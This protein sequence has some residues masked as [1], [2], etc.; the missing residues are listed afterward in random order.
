METTHSKTR[1]AK[2]SSPKIVIQSWNDVW[3]SF[4][5]DNTLTTIEA[6]NAEGWKTVDQ[7]IKMT[8]LSNARI[9]NL[10]REE[11]FEREKK[12]VKDGGVVKIINFVR[13]KF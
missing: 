5:K 6:M 12:K 13:P 7:V 11:K 8:G 10:I 4:G 3:E 2:S 9:Y 1:R